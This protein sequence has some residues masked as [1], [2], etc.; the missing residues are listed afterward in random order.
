[1]KGGLDVAMN[2]RILW[3]L[4]SILGTAFYVLSFNVIHK[5]IDFTFPANKIG[6][7]SAISWIIFGMVL[8]IVTKSIPSIKAWVDICLSTMAVGI[9][10]LMTGVIFNFIIFLSN[11]LINFQ[12]FL[13][14]HLVILIT[15]DL[16]MGKIFIKESEPLGLNP[17]KAILLWISC[18]NGIFFSILF[19]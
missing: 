4:I 6:M 7:A 8:L 17:S 14:I 5:N 15:S 9:A 1:M 3:G 13:L 11:S 16:S 19:I 18:L 2:R 12:T 10:I